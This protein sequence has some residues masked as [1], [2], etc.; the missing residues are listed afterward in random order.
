MKPIT[1]NVPEPVYRDL[2][3]YARTHDRTTS[4][5]I[6]EALTA[7][8]DRLLSTRQSLKTLRPLDL[9]KMRRPLGPED[10]LLGEMMDAEGH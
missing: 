10:D 6:R 5:L 4:E 3:S 7:Y 8:R 2:Q 9:G 1:V